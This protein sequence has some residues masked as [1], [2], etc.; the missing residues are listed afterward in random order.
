MCIKWCERSE[1]KRRENVESGEE[2]KVKRAGQP[3][4]TKKKKKKN[5]KQNQRSTY[6]RIATSWEST[7][8]A[9]KRKKKERKYKIT[10]SLVLSA[11]YAPVPKHNTH[12]RDRILFFPAL[13]LVRTNA[14]QCLPCAHQRTMNKQRAREQDDEDDGAFVTHGQNIRVH[15]TIQPNENRYS[16]PSA[17]E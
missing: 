10:T 4:A 16:A 2:K 9:R 13:S 12:K 11:D 8:W 6:K 14:V 7:K 1:A 5:S 3:N 17:V 15:S